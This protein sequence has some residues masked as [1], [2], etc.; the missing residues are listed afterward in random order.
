MIWAGHIAR[1]LKKK[2]KKAYRLPGNRPL[3]RRRRRWVDNIR[4]NLG[5]VESGG[6]DWIYLTQGFCEHVPSVPIKC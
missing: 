4:M 6:I 3:G 5:G 1:I 2:K